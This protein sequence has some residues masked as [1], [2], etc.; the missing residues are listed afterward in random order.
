MSFMDMATLANPFHVWSEL[1]SGLRERFIAELGEEHGPLS[2]YASETLGNL[3]A[4]VTHLRHLGLSFARLE[5]QDKDAFD[6]F[7]RALERS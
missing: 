1:A 2:P 3:A 5:S 6:A 7:L 4:L